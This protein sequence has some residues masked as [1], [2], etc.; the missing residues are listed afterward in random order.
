MYKVVSGKI[1]EL[2]SR[3]NEAVEAGFTEFFREFPPTLP[4]VGSV[5]EMSL[6]STYHFMMKKPAELQTLFP[7]VDAIDGYVTVFRRL[8]TSLGLGDRLPPEP[9]SADVMKLV[10][11]PPLPQ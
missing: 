2:E 5:D 8:A 1:D 4:S 9:K 10:P 6:T 3:M 11:P 7:S